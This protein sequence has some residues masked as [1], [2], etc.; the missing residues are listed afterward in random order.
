MTLPVLLASDA[1]F[2]TWLGGTPKEAYGLV[3]SYE[4]YKMRIVQSGFEKKD[5]VG[6]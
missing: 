6:V 2:D 4:S 1:D 5:L 3:R